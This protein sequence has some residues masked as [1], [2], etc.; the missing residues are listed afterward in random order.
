MSGLTYSV[1]IN[2]YIMN[3]PS[4][5]IVSIVKRLKFDE[6]KY[7]HLIWR[8]IVW[9]I[10]RSIKLVKTAF[11]PAD[12][13]DRQ[14]LPDWDQPKFWF[15]DPVS[16][17]IEDEEARRR[18]EEK[19][20]PA[21]REERREPQQEEQKNPVEVDD[22]RSVLFERSLERQKYEQNLRIQIYIKITCSKE[23][24]MISWLRIIYNL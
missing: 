7:M 6:R 19:R 13:G 9:A 12:S 22:I 24:R 4:W 23:L 10:D 18:V 11:S 16:N 3:N 17:P 20:R 15:Q 2:G 1:I 5:A 14:R 21:E 8:N